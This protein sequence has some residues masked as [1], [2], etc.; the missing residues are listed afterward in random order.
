M[1]SRGRLLAA[2]L[3]VVVVAA[4]A[5]VVALDQGVAAPSARLEPD[6]D[7]LARVI[8]SGPGA[9]LGAVH[10][11]GPHGKAIAITVRDG[12]VYPR[13]PQ[14]VGEKVVVSAEI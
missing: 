6:P 8:V 3:G 1:L 7:A 13:D 10:A 12:R 9:S 5:G 2:G 14:P 4:G 11:V